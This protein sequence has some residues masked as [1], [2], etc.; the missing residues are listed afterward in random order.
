MD[1]LDKQKCGRRTHD[2]WRGVNWRRG[3]ELEL[4]QKLKGIRQ[5]LAKLPVGETNDACAKLGVT[6]LYPGAF[7]DALKRG[8]PDVYSSSSRMRTTFADW[9]L[10]GG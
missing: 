3:V 4:G 2:D 6:A 1:G 8:A 9:R 5:G 10:C 7:A